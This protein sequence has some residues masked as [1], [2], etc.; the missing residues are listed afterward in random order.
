M[1]ITNNQLKQIIKEELSHVLQEAGMQMATA[2]WDDE[3]D[4]EQKEK[5]ALA[6]RQMKDIETVIKLTNSY[7]KDAVKPPRWEQIAS[8]DPNEYPKG[9]YV[10][11]KNAGIIAVV[12]PNGKAIRLNLGRAQRKHFKSIETDV[13]SAG[14][15]F[16]NKLKP[17]LNINA[18]TGKPI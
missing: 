14:F 7:V 16:N 11:D 10:S 13:D 6:K 18:L 15:R 5:E 8:V 2:S 4:E 9:K 12:L 3:P 17:L 1:K